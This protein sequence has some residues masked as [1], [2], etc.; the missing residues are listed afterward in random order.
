MKRLFVTL[1]LAVMLISNSSFASSDPQD[2][3]STFYKTFRNA[4]NVTWGD[5]E[6]MTRIGFTILGQ[7]QFA[8]YNNNDL[9]VLAKRIEVKDLPAA[10]Q[11][12]LSTKY[13]DYAQSELYEV[14]SNG[15]KEYCITLDNGSKHLVLKGTRKWG[16]FLKEKK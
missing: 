6:G 9:V 2:A 16:V 13:S 8:Y 12:E 5:V 14:E 10:L 7:E 15:T 3:L 4:E 1:G 11:K